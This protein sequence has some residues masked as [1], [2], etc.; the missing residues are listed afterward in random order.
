MKRHC[1]FGN[2]AAE[3]VWLKSEAPGCNKTI[4]TV[5]VKFLDRRSG[6]NFLWQ[7]VPQFQRAHLPEQV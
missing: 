1:W 5:P 7:G 6:R 3:A 2:L 4:I